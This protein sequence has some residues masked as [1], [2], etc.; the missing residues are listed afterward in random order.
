MAK[1]PRK[2]QQKKP[3][4]YIPLQH[5]DV[6][7]I[8]RKHIRQVLPILFWLNRRKQHLSP[9]WPTIKMVRVHCVWMLAFWGH[10]LHPSSCCLLAFLWYFLWCE[11]FRGSPKM[12]FFM[13][14]WC[15]SNTS[16]SNNQS[17]YS[18]S[19][20]MNKCVIFC[21]KLL[22]SASIST[23]KTLEMY[24][25]SLVYGKTKKTLRICQTR[26]HTA[27]SLTFVCWYHPTKKL[28]TLLHRLF[29]IQVAAVL[30]VFFSR[31]QWKIK[32]NDDFLLFRLF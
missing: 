23:R 17:A 20:N 29:W 6:T 21:E 32:H 2:L 15:I 4:S 22:R 31:H 10:P 3:L 28:T 5:W 30:V 18:A 25:S 7:A 13:R 16:W 11:I 24:E 8:R 26:P 9:L 12:M 27:E 19:K 14:N 1:Y